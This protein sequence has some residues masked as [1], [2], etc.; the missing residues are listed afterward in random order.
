MFE[1][2][3]GRMTA[4]AAKRVVI[5]FAHAKG[6]L[7]PA[8][9]MVDAQTGGAVKAA[10]RGSRFGGNSGEMAKVTV[11]DGPVSTVLVAGLG[12]ASAMGRKEWWKAGMGLGAQ[13]DA[14][15]VKE[16]TVALGDGDGNAP[17]AEQALALLEGMQMAMYRFESFK[18]ELKPEQA[19]K[20]KKVTVLTSAAAAKA[21]AAEAPRLAKLM[22]S[23]DVA[24]NAANT[25]P[26][27]ANPQ[28]MVDEAKKLEKLGVKV[29]VFDEK[30]LKKMGCNLILA[31]GGNA[32]DA[33]QPRMV[34]MKYEGA[35]KGAPYTAVVGKG[36]M[37]DTGG[38]NAKPGNYMRGM[39]FD[40]C[41]AAAVLGTMRALAA[42]K[43]KVNV[44]G[45][46]SCAMNMIGKQAFV[47]D[48][49]YTGYK[50]I[51]VEIG[52]TDAEG[53]L[54]LAD[55]I[56]YTIDKHKPAEL[57][58][59]ATLTGAC[60]VALGGGY[61]GLFSTKDALANALAKAG[62]N[63]GELLW[64]LPVDDYFTSK[65]EVADIC[66][67]SN[68][69]YGG[70]SVA[71]AFLKKFADKTPWAHL[72]IAGVANADKIPGANKHLKGGTGFGV[73]LLVNWL[74]GAKAV[75]EEDAKPAKRGRGRPKGSGKRRGP[76]R[77][78]KNG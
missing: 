31:V 66:N 37:F 26:N 36:I 6:A 10:L 9:A 2:A 22:E 64:R 52:H 29:E 35:G 47:M 53:R 43:A 14:M 50:G 48:S 41:G 58:D 7:T 30:Q 77:P 51:T 1:I 40:M 16:V 65:S 44:V 74:E 12:K 11:Q 15:G 59:L 60:M 63:V 57:V 55:A 42:R 39:K 56:A 13:V 78:R 24:R 34:V 25:P 8:A 45:V 67:D 21:V 70:A 75:D 33:D 54:V 3:T 68:G 62:E 27:V 61:A 5:V 49:V 28:F 38:Y 18:T 32:D 73:R 19:A 76:G 72:D 23:V 4:K 71:A 17:L 46:M 20:L 69:G